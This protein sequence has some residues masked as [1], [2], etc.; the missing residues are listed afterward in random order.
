MSDVSQ[1]AF[2]FGADDDALADEPLDDPANPTYT[3][4]ELA[5]EIN[6]SSPPHV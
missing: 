1:P 5:D 2:D 4:C 3:V 6:R